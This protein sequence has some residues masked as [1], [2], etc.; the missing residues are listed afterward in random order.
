MNLIVSM[1][2]L[3]AV[4]CQATG[5]A[6]TTQSSYYQLDV[7]VKKFVDLAIIK[8]NQ[9]HTFGHLNFFLFFF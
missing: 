9:Q 8:A 1:L 7:R 3:T 5:Q 6:H 2:F 4:V